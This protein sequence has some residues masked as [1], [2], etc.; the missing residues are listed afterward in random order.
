MNKEATC[1]FTGHRPQ[2]LPWGYDEDWPDCIRLKVR[3]GCEIEAMRQKGV[4]D[5]ISGMAVGVDLWAA[6]IVV[7][8][9]RAYPEDTIRLFA[10]IPFEG[11]ANKWSSEYRERYYETL[12]KADGETTLYAHYNEGCTFERNRYMV[13]HS[14]HMIAV[15]NGEKKGGTKYTVDYARSKGLEIVI[16]NPE[17]FSRTETPRFRGFKLLK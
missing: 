10:A 8:L 3:L 2:K 17:D 4:T 16:I 15:Y 13:D 9:K 12:A 7:D 11:Q 14:A 5:F 6:E 1:C